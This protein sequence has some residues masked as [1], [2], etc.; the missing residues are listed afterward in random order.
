MYNKSLIAHSDLIVKNSILNQGGHGIVSH[1]LDTLSESS[2]A[3]RTH[4]H[5]QFHILDN[6]DNEA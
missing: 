5:Q 1:F 2:A 6:D 3:S 4:A